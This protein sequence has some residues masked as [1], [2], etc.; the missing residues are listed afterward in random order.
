M[1]EHVNDKC[2]GKSKLSQAGI[3]LFC[4]PRVQ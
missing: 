1:I 2:G 4:Q 3:K